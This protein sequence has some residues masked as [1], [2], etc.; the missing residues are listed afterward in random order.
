MEYVLFTYPN[1][2]KCN[3]VKNYLK[4]KQ[5][6]YEEVNAGLGEGKL[7][8]RSFY[9]E[10]KDKIQREKDGSII[11]PIFKYNGTILQGLEGIIDNINL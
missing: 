2:G 11:L 6:K 5:I 9:S 3:E 1:C 8:F 7:K 4:E 10:N